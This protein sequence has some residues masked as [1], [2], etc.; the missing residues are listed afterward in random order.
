MDNL[1]KLK[2]HSKIKLIIMLLST[3]LPLIIVLIMSIGN[4]KLSQY[5]VFAKAPYLPVIICLL[6][7]SYLAF[8]IYTYIRILIND[9]YARATLIKRNDE[10]N[11]YIQLKSNALIDKIFV[12]VMGIVVIFTAFVNHAVFWPCLG[13]FLIFIGIHI[14]VNIY[15]NKKY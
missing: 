5:S 6:F 11:K 2:Y 3:A 10:R 7:E 9:A 13:I 12:Y 14:V 4:F 8:K 15:Y 1:E